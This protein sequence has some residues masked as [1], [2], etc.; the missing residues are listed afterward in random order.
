MFHPLSEIA[1]WT[2]RLPV[3]NNCFAAFCV[4]LHMVGVK[5]VSQKR[6]A[7]GAFIAAQQSQYFALP[8]R[9]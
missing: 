1:F 7:D 9:K 6:A 5:L 8:C 4:R 3:S 2:K